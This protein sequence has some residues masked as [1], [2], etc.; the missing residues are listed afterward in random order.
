MSK[1]YDFTFEVSSGE[2]DYIFH[3]SPCSDLV[4]LVVQR[5]ERNVYESDVAA[6]QRGLTAAVRRVRDELM[7]QV[8]AFNEALKCLDIDEK[9]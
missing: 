9:E 5:Y 8:E 2:F 4:E 6:P 7:G 1:A 3:K